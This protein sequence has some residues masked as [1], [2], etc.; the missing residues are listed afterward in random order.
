MVEIVTWGLMEAYTFWKSC[1]VYPKSTP[2]KME[3]PHF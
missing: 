1:I 3:L 2:N